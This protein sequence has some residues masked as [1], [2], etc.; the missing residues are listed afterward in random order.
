LGGTETLCNSRDWYWV[1]ALSDSEMK[2]K[3]SKLWLDGVVGAAFGE[4]CIHSSMRSAENTQ[5]QD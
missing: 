2:P 4:K 3:Y 5:V 1:E